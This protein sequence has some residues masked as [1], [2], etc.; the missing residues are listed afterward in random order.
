V[1][2]EPA[3]YDLVVESDDGFARIQ[4]KSTSARDV[5]RWAV[6]IS[7]REYT[8]GILNAGGARKDCVYRDTEI[9]YF[10]IV[11]GDG[12]QYIIPLK[13]TNGIGHITLDSKYAAFRVQLWK[14]NRQAHW[15]RP[16]SDARRKRRQ[17][18]VL[19]L[20]PWRMNR[21]GHRLRLE[22]VWAPEGAGHRALRPPRAGAKRPGRFKSVV[23]A[24][25]SHPRAGK[26][27]LESEPARVAGAVS[28]A[29]GRSRCGSSPPLSSLE[30]APPA[31][32]RAL[33]TRGGP[34]R[35]RRSTLPPSALRPAR[36]RVQGS[37]QTLSRG[38]EPHALDASRAAPGQGMSAAGRGSMATAHP[39]VG[40]ALI[41]RYSSVRLRGGQLGRIPS[42]L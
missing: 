3:P 30:G 29:A 14:V 39:V 28:N 19:R 13:A 24:R 18:R 35:S 1:P 10:F 32:Q 15:A 6:S 12:S 2:T 8:P 22:S 23:S 34:S 41:R 16:L 38:H 37:R 5:G 4:V 17:F 40:A 27:A 25:G 20:P 11:A 42:V 26:Q 36:D 31:R 33:N 7:R 9:D 21:S